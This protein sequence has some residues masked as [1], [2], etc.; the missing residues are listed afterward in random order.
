MKKILHNNNIKFVV[1]SDLEKYRVETIETKEPETIAWINSW[2]YSG[3]IFF[4]VG[5][6][7]G[8]YS[9]YAA[10]K[11]N[12]IQVYAFEPDPL[13][14][15]SLLKNIE[16]NSLS[17]IIHPLNLAV[18]EHL[19]SSARFSCDD[20]RPGRSGG[21]VLD[22]SNIKN[23]NYL[24][25][26]INLDFLVYTCEFPIP[27]HIKIDVDGF[28]SRVLQGMRRLLTSSTLKGILVEYNNEEEYSYWNNEISESGLEVD[29]DL[30]EI[31]DHSK[32]R[33]QSKGSSAKNVIYKRRT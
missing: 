25:T 11:I 2:P 32:F 6:N 17:N 24:V 22:N 3:N 15:I 9:L 30:E 21:Q 28:E 10:Q 7:I 33:R 8:I 4:D 12:N 1:N 31:I 29:Y 14:F 27:T 16:I 26:V 20:E 5:A 19:I 23:T 18:G 13:N